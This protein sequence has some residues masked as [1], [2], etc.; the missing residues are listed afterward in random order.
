MAPKKVTNVEKPKRK[1]IMT[2]EEM[3]KK[4]LITKWEKGTRVPDLAVQCGFY[5]IC[6]T[7][8]A[9]ISLHYTF[10]LCFG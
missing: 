1:I 3:K 5:G 6:L 4:E 7:F 9:V 2:T 8:Q 10:Y